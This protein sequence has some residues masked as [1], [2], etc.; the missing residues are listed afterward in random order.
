VSFFDKIRQAGQQAATRAK[1]EL[2]VMQ[3]KREISQAY[4]QLGRRAAE[5]VK[6]GELS[7]PEAS[8]ITERIGRLEAE[9]AAAEKS[10]SAVSA[11]T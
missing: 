7:D 5:L 2:D 6:A 9:L 1:E 3:R 10:E 8:S 11:E 4:G